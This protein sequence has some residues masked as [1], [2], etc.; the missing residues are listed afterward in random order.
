[1]SSERVAFLGL[2][3][4]GIHMAGYILKRKKSLVVWNR[5]ASKAD[6]LK[7]VG[8]DLTIA[9]TQKEAVNSAS[10][11]I[12]MLFD[13]KVNS[14]FVDALSPEDVK[15]KTF[16]I[17]STISV[18]LSKDLHS[19]I[20]AKGG[21][22]IEC[23]VLGNNKV[24]ES[25][26]LQ[27]LFGGTEA[28]F[29]KHKDLLS[30]FGTPKYIGSIGQAL[31]CKLALNEMILAILSGFA[32]SMGIIEKAGVDK[33]KFLDIVMNGPMALPYLSV[34]E[35]KMSNHNYNDVNFSL[36]G[37]FKDISLVI[38]RIKELELDTVY[39]EGIR[40]LVKNALEADPKNP[41]LDMSAVFEG[42]NKK[43]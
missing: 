12:S 20:L 7:E 23:P 19:R 15:G 13:D 2:G 6:P 21:D 34:W 35:K 28:Q 25:G 27:V 26:K 40:S 18:K 17:M 41:E 31:S 11:I 9:N 38:E 32:T 39:T 33:A 3:L 1:M 5:T 8:G 24:A 10:V 22:Y 37:A 43:K 36:A 30:S 29:E 4:M 16:I 14:E 42:V